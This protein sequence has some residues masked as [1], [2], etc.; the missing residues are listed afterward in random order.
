MPQERDRPA[1]A[2]HG[3]RP[4]PLTTANRSSPPRVLLPKDLDV[5]RR[6]IKA[7]NRRAASKV[8]S[9]AMDCGMKQA[10]AF[11]KILPEI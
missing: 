1:L 6:L 5:I 4:S 11:I 8:Y 3:G 9:G 2:P 10:A 7:D